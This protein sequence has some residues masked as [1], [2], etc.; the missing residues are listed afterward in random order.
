ME[1]W[2]KVPGIKGL[3]CIRFSISS[4][5]Q[6]HQSTTMN[7]TSFVFAVLSVALVL[8]TSYPEVAQACWW[9]PG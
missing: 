4:T 8:M 3:A 2:V 7:F 6:P 9:V 1:N 5:E